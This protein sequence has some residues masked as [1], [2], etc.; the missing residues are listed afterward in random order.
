LRAVPS[1]EPPEIIQMQHIIA[2][3]ALQKPIAIEV[4][5]EPQGV[6]IPSAQGFRF[7]AVRLPVFP[8]DGVI[9]ES[10]EAAQAAAADALD[11]DIEG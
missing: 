4:A 5:G 10:V 8:L 11:S 6:V 9:F 1:D 2:Q 7:M 3:P